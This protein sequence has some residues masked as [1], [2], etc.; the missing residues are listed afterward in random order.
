MIFF[1]AENQHY[2]GAVVPYTEQ[3]GALWPA[4][5]NLDECFARE[6]LLSFPL[7]LCQFSSNRHKTRAVSMSWAA[8]AIRATLNLWLQSSFSQSLSCP[9]PSFSGCDTTSA[10]R[11]KSKKSAW[12][13]WQASEDATETFVDLAEHPF[14]LLGVGCQSS[15]V[16]FVYIARLLFTKVSQRGSNGHS[17]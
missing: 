5:N 14:Q 1:P 10:F 8:K 9:L 7:R 13:V 12:R 11:G 17:W 3:P 15:Q 2:H 6:V 16:K 4:E